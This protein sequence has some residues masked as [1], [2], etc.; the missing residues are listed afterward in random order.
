MTRRPRLPCTFLRYHLL[1][2][3][4]NTRREDMHRNSSEVVNTRIRQQNSLHQDYGAQSSPH[5][6]TLVS[7]GMLLS[8]VKQPALPAT[9]P[10]IP[11]HLVILIEDLFSRFLTLSLLLESMHSSHHNSPFVK[12][13]PAQRPAQTQDLFSSTLAPTSQQPQLVMPQNLD[14]FTQ[15]PQYGALNQNSMVP[16]N[17]LTIPSGVQPLWPM[18]SPLMEHESPR[19]SPSPLASYSQLLTTSHAYSCRSK[20]SGRFAAQYA[21]V[22]RALEFFIRSVSKL[23][24]TSRSCS[25][26]AYHPTNSP[27][28]FRAFGSAFCWCA[29]SP[30]SHIQSISHWNISSWV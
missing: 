12:A 29:T 27:Q 13:M 18:P 24:A 11:S 28:A 15:Q 22:R 19:L 10:L 4:P 6:A 26:D 8:D 20:L 17:L 9:I 16:Y 1:L 5:H 7:Q 23:F 14:V 30:C 2:W 21:W 3:I 25:D